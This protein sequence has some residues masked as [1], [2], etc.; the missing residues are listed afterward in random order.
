MTYYPTLDILKMMAAVLVVAIH[1]EPFSG[2]ANL[3][4]IDLLAHTAVPIFFITSSFFFYKNQQTNEHLVK[5]LRR[6]AILY[7]VWFVLD[8]PLTTAIVLT[9]GTWSEGLSSLAKGLFFGSTFR[10]SWY[11]MA[12]MECITVIYFLQ[13]YCPTWLLATIGLLLFGYTAIFNCYPQVELPAPWFNS[14]NSFMVGFIYVVI[15]KIF[16]QNELKI[17]SLSN[18]A[19]IAL[20]VF[21]LVALVELIYVKNV[22]G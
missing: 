4:L 17:S 9:H 3:L 21:S 1:C 16:A 6:L 2:V 22:G 10:G 20:P 15:G 14:N 11:I 8:I 12:L 7:A 13:K 19:K 5:S 18:V